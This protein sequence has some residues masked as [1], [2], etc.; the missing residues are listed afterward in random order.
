MKDQGR[1]K[2]IHE[3]HEEKNQP[4]KN[5][6]QKQFLG[7]KINKNSECKYNLSLFS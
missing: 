1:K 3:S 7:S 5:S 6:K 4:Q 2:A